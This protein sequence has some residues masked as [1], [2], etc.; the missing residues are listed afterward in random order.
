MSASEVT[1]VWRY[2]NSIIIIIIN[3]YVLRSS[4]A[5]D[6]PTTGVGGVLRSDHSVPV[7]PG[8]SRCVE[9]R[10]RCDTHGTRTHSA[11]A[12]DAMR[13]HDDRRQQ[14]AESVSTDTQCR[15]CSGVGVEF[16]PLPH[17]LELTHRYA[18][19]ANIFFLMPE[20]F[21]HERFLALSD[22]ENCLFSPNNYNLR[23]SFK[24]HICSVKLDFNFFWNN[25]KVCSN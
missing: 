3:V 13:C 6:G 1:T 5:G 19:F 10:Q 23:L 17:K 24:Q 18:A 11:A 16:L 12:A 7:S 8:G 20:R 15:S 22:A 14:E 9:R 4:S 2:R 25:H 21:L